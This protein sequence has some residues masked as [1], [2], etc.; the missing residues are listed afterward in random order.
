[1]DESAL[2]SSIKASNLYKINNSKSLVNN[3]IE[4]CDGVAGDNKVNPTDKT[5]LT[6]AVMK[7]FEEYKWTPPTSVVK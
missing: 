7:V 2:K 4:D 3:E 5:K 6:L 1:M